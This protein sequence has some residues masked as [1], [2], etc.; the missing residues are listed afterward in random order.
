MCQVQAQCTY[1][2][3]AVSTPLTLNGWHVQYDDTQQ[4]SVKLYTYTCT[5]IHT[6]I[7]TIWSSPSTSHT[8]T[9]S[10]QGDTKL[11]GWLGEKINTY[12][13][14]YTFVEHI[15]GSFSVEKG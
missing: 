2:C 12:T 4:L 15:G 9:Q 5:H 1:L 7:H 6:Y 10:V 3:R 13:Y 11:E 8:C 14:M